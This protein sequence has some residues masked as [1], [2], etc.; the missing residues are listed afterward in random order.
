[1]SIHALKSWT[2]L[3]K[4]HTDVESGSLAEAVFAIDLGAIATRDETTPKVYLDPDAFF[5]ATYITTDLQRLLEE[6]LSSLAGKGSFGRTPA[7]GAIGSHAVAAK[8]A[9]ADFHRLA[10]ELLERMGDPQLL[11]AAHIERRAE[12]AF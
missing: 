3:V 7:V 9:R 4:L 8:V 12:L 6:V 2:E 10:K 1:M 11:A 5:A